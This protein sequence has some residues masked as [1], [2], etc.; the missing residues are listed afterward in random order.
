[1]AVNEILIKL[2]ADSAALVTGMNQAN[3][4]LGKFENAA[5]KAK[6]A[7][8]AIGI[9]VS[10]AGVTSVIKG[11]IDAADGLRDMAQQTGLT[12]EALSG[13]QLVAK[14]SGTDLDG[15]TRGLKALSKHQAEAAAGSDK[16][17]TFLSGLGVSST[18]AQDS[19]I[20]LADVFQKMPDGM[21]KMALA[22]ELFGK[23]GLDMIP[24]LNEGSAAIQKWMAEGAKAGPTTAMAEQADA[25]NDSM[26]RIK[27]QLGGLATAVATTILP[28]LTQV[29]E[30][31]AEHPTIAGWI[32]LGAASAV[33]IG[34]AAGPIVAG[35]GAIAA[36]LTTAATVVMAHP[37]LAII[38]GA[39]AVGIAIYKNWDNI[40][41]AFNDGV[42]KVKATLANWKQIGMDMI[43]GLYQGIMATIRKPLDAIG[44][45]AKKL[46]A[47]AKDLLGIKSPSRVFMGIGE[48]IGAGLVQG[49]E[50][51]MPDAQSATGKLIE[52]VIV[53]PTNRQRTAGGQFK[54]LADANRQGTGIAGGLSEYMDSIRS[55]ADAMKDVTVKAFQGMEDALVSFVQKGK[56]DF[57]SLAN[58]IV[59]D[60][61]RIQ[62]QQ[63]ITKPLAAAMSGFSLSSFKFWANGGIPGGSGISAY[64]NTVVD[65]PTIFPFARGAGLMGEA[66]PEAI[67]PLTRIGGRLGVD[68]SAAAPTINVTVNNN[69]SQQVQ[70][71]VH[72]HQGPQGT[73]LQI[74]IDQIEAAIA[75]NVSRGRGALSSVL[76]GQYGLN[77]AAGAV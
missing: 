9:G 70:A 61:I 6:S 13:F 8:A 21:E 43:E 50:S 32:G 25:F 27:T 65:R 19:L 3:G 40:V 44:D 76:G 28:A 69:A 48:E 45:L 58:S 53:E 59:A 1:M 41:A 37:V 64:R 18:N 52:A 77:R 16:M 71:T 30:W 2:A 62:I 72:Q 10:M 47:W 17:K 24:M 15:I 38:F 23:A 35:I 39:V 57:K 20:K 14:M 36:A 29:A 60:L 26:E 33:V 56:L 49:I 66:G 55:S 7:L 31:A 5:A 67:M 68:A 51:S 22:Q 63:N 34:F 4:A 42:K 54:T 74:Q 75:R 46:P 73:T 11:S 12:V